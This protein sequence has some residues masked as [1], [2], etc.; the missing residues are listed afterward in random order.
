MGSLQGA[1][2]TGPVTLKGLKNGTTIDLSSQQRS[3]QIGLQGEDLGQSSGSVGHFG[4]PSGTGGNF[5]HG[6]CS[7]NKAL[8]IVKKACIG[9]S[10]CKINVSIDTFGDPCRR[11][12]K[13]LAV[14]ASCT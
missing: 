12:T 2:I 5:N 3:Y 10:S 1:R 11:V 14:E 9:L 7:S 6:S 4:T 13:S 8:S